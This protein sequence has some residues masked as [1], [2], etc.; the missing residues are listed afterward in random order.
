MDELEA[1]V[2]A[3]RPAAP[4]ASSGV[5][6]ALDE[7]QETTRSQAMRWTPWRRL[8]R[9][10]RAFAVVAV[11][12][13]TGTGVATA[14]V[15][16][17]RTGWFTAAT[18]E[19]DTTE[20]LNTDAGDFPGVVASLAPSYLTYPAGSNRAQA[21]RWVTSMSKGSG[22]LTQQT[23]VVRGYETFAQCGWVRAWQAAST[24]QLAKQASEQLAA[25]ASWPAFA[26][27]D[28]GGVVQAMQAM[29]AAARRGDK[30]GVATYAAIVCPEGLIAP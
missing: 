4:T 17:A 15:I 20:W 3:A 12:A 8:R 5:L 22:G 29:A 7:L 21:Q 13:V 10:Q 1:L 14:A 25:S 28:G 16:S 6:A 11:L 30:P 23:S 18:S 19:Q 27:T 2:L 24:P 26:A 9:A